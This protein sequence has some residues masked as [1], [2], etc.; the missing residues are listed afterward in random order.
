[1]FHLPHHFGPGREGGEMEMSMDTVDTC[2]QDK[3]TCLILKRQFQNILPQDDYKKYG[4]PTEKEED[5]GGRQ[6]CHC[7]ECFPSLKPNRQ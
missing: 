7:R 5:N 3:M 6:C 1:M 4:E 2:T